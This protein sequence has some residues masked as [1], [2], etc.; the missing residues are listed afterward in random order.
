M[1]DLRCA[2]YELRATDI[3]LTTSQTFPDVIRI[4]LGC[5]VYVEVGGK[6]ADVEAEAAALD[7]L[8]ELAT[9][10]AAQLRAASSGETR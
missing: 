2:L 9:Q 4:D 5:G 10:A 8:A 6:G 3:T 7:R 1:A